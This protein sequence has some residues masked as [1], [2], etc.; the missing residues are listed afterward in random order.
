MPSFAS[1]LSI[2]IVS[3][4][5]C[6]TGQKWKLPIEPRGVKVTLPISKKVKI[7]DFLNFAQRCLGRFWLTEKLFLLAQIDVWMALGLSIV[8]LGQPSTLGAS[9]KNTS[10]ELK[11]S[12]LGHGYRLGRLGWLWL[13]EK[14]FLL[15]YFD[16]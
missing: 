3:D 2:H 8:D 12:Y 7:S 10:E 16:V 6:E 9:P 14:L 5:K 13:I 15:V 1:N 11:K 4:E